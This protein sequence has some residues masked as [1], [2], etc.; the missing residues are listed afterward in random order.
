M[1]TLDLRL[2]FIEPRGG[3]SIGFLAIAEGTI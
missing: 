2:G 3:W 1:M